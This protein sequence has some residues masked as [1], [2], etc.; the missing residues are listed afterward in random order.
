MLVR[1]QNGLKGTAYT[2]ISV[3]TR[4][5]QTSCSFFQWAEFDDDG[6]PPWAQKVSTEGKAT[7]EGHLPEPE[8]ACS[9]T[10]P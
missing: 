7:L 4:I 2:R 3:A 9:T 1:L 8:E 10:G 5:D 6:K